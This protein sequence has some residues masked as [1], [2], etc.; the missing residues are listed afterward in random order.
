MSPRACCSLQSHTGHIG[1]Q[2]KAHF[3]I[4]IV[5]RENIH[6]RSHLLRKYSLILWQAEELCPD[7][8]TGNDPIPGDNPR[9]MAHSSRSSTSLFA[10]LRDHWRGNLRLRITVILS[11]L[12]GAIMVIAS[13]V[14]YAE[15]RESLGESSRARAQAIGRTFTAIA[16]TALAENLYL[17]QE[18][19]MGYT[20][21]P[22][23]LRVDI[24]DTDIMI[25]ASMESVRI[26]HTLDDRQLS[27]AQRLG[28]EVIEYGSAADGTLILIAVEPLRDKGTIAG[29]VR[30][31]FSLSA[32]QRDLTRAVWQSALLA[33]VLIG[34][35]ILIAEFS[36]RRTSILFRD[37]ANR[38][39]AELHS[40]HQRFP[41]LG[42]AP[43]QSLEQ[44]S[45]NIPAGWGE[46][47]RTVELINHTIRLLA[48]QTQ[49]IQT[50]TASLETAV[51]DR[52][53]HAPG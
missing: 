28:D 40:L 22:D 34:A 13:T 39:Q 4:A 7:S 46:I 44:P 23:V 36:M 53:K 52:T 48:S 42:S 38:L 1:G 51:A 14:R 11:V 32:M 18:A 49:A 50:F 16:S 43:G 26:G 31:E 24:L 27:Q 8:G 45:F 9:I 6:E 12:L 33:I 47:E 41:T 35:S 25:I 29:W 20:H 21:D 10:R 17:I 30:I 2:E 19:L 5:R 15:I 3:F 37:T